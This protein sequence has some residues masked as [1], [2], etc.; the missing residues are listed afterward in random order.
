MVD[1]LGPANADN[2][3]TARPPETR[4]FGSLDTFFK[5]CTSEAA[6]DGT[7]VEAS[8]FNGLI[9]KLRGV[10]R[11]NGKLADNTTLIVAE[12]DSDDLGIVKS[13]QQLFQR[14]QPTYAV[15]TGA[16]NAM[17]VTLSPALK[18][19][20][21][22]VSIKVKVAA[23]NTGA[24]TINVNGL[25]V[26]AVK[27]PDGTD[28]VADDL[29]AGGMAVLNDDGD[30]FHL[31]AK[32]TDRTGDGAGGGGT[33]YRVPYVLATGTASVITATYDPV[34]PSPTAGDLFSI[35]LAADIA[36]ATTFTPDGHGPYPIVDM[37]GNALISKFA[38]AGD[39]LLFEFDGTN[40]VVL[41]K[42][43]LGTVGTMTPGAIGSLGLSIQAT[44]L[45][46]YVDPAISPSAGYVY[47]KYVG[48]ADGRGADNAG[49]WTTGSFTG[50]WRVLSALYL[51]TFMDPF[52]GDP[53]NNPMGANPVVLVQRVS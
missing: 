16:A 42:F 36:G 11:M 40:M 50:T 35:K 21:A 9:A 52:A 30:H 8:F 53:P 5:D 10:W 6:N 14:G 41:N 48:D 15:D 1:I 46:G 29:F 13:I 39:R 20:K 27:N 38:K 45:A 12:T 24:T 19:Y 34:T 25:G 3:V 31:L 44:P 32:H 22:G 2:A 51:G 23:N 28:L 37:S 33:R 47:G 49:L 18:E 43:S 26:R 7:E 4:A 17:V